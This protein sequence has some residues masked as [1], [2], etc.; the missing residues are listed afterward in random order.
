M[1]VKPH[2]LGPLVCG[3]APCKGSAAGGGVTCPVVGVPAAQQGEC[4]SALAVTLG[5]VPLFAWDLPCMLCL[6]QQ[7]VMDLLLS[8]CRV[9]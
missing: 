8:R 7:A 3:I 5:D 1:E 9:C 6:L 4:C 2:P